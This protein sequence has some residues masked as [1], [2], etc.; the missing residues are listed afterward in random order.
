MSLYPSH[1][2]DPTLLSTGNPLLPSSRLSHFLWG[3]LDLRVLCT[4]GG[5]SLGGQRDLWSLQGP[6]RQPDSVLSAVLTI[7]RV[8]ILAG[9]PVCGCPA[10]DSL[11]KPSRMDP[12]KSLPG[13]ILCLCPFSFIS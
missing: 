2:H 8:E 13:H 4:G 12:L 9:M 7:A 6:L 11:G 1:L 5:V 3:P 10:P